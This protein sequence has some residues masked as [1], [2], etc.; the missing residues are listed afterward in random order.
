MAATLAAI[1]CCEEAGAWPADKALEEVAAGDLL[2]GAAAAACE[3]GCG[4][5]EA[6]D[7]TLGA[8]GQQVEHAGGHL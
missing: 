6:V 3:A 2:Q 4:L 5:G 1:S 7:T 8:V